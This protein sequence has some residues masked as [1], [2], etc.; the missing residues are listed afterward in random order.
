MVPLLSVAP[1]KR[2]GCVFQV[3]PPVPDSVQ[4]LFARYEAGPL[5]VPFVVQYTRSFALWIG[6]LTPLVLKRM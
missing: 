2:A 3:T 6:P 5:F 4:L 1:L